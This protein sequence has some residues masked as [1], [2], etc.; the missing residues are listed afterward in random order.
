MIGCAASRRASDPI[1]PRMFGHWPAR[2]HT[3]RQAARSATDDSRSNGSNELSKAAS[4]TTARV[5]FG[6][7]TANTWAA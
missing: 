5:L 6:C 7:R 4:T 3:A 1:D 2:A